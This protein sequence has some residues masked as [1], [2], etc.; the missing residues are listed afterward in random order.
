MHVR[1]RFVHNVLMHDF[2]GRRAADPSAVLFL[3]KRR[4]IDRAV[5]REPGRLMSA[6]A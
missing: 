5:L 1:L 4:P 2:V 6:P 3:A